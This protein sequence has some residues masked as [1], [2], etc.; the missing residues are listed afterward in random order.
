MLISERPPV[1]F[2]ASRNVRTIERHFE[3]RNLAPG[4]PCPIEPNFVQIQLDASIACY[5]RLARTASR[6]R[7]A[8]DA[9]SNRGG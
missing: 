1:F 4:P 2:S 5:R 3:F 9:L 7:T 8:S 6:Q